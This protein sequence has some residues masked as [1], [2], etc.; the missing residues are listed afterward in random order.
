MKCGP[1]LIN[2]DLHSHSLRSDGTLSPHDLL[3]R[4][5][6][7][8]VNL[9]ALTDH[10]DT[11]G[12]AEARLAAEKTAI[13]LVNGVEISVSWRG[14][15][16]H[17]VGLGIDPAYCSLQEGL[18]VTRNGRVERAHKIALAL[19]KLGID[20]SLAGAQ[21]FCANPQ[22]IGRAHFARFL[23]QQNV[24]R[25]F[26]SAF[27]RF[28]GSGQPA[29]VEHQWPDLIDAVSWIKGSGGVAVVAHPH[30]YP[31]D[32][33]LMRE[34]LAEFRDLGGDAIE[35][36]TSSDQRYRS[37][38]FAQYLRHYGFAASTGS[39]FHSPQE[40]YHDLGRLP[41]LPSSCTPVWER[42]AL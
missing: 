35:V 16:V 33:L 7:R 20:G 2:C 26:G 28:L 4:A 41:P 21:Q 14:Y 11:S 3:A 19:E 30:R 12:L 36:A 1:R 39:D 8:G 25:D 13:C 29:C 23:V 15:S 38:S 9:L 10:D 34:L 37:G 31:V 17:I 32:D 42:F 40:S 24:V 18:A 22:M 27:K 6:Q 5:V